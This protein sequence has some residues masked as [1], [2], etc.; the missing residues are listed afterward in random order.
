MVY[1]SL[2]N[3]CMNILSKCVFESTRVDVTFDRY[4]W[5]SGNYVMM[6][7]LSCITEAGTGP[8]ADD[9]CRDFIAYP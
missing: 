6:I 7:L 5:S 4:N 2:W 1:F 9:L 3:K 8:F